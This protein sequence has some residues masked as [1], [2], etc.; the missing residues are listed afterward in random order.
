VLSCGGLLLTIL[1]LAEFWH[2]L[3]KRQT[4]DED[5]GGREGMT[6]APKSLFKFSAYSWYTIVVLSTRPTCM[7]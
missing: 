5:G 6:G 3:Q 2:S 7:K 1:S 4:A